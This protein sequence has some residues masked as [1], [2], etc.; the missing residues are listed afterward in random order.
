MCHSPGGENVTRRLLAALAAR[1]GLRR[2]GDPGLTGKCEDILS[3]RAFAE[4][5]ERCRE[6]TMTSL[7]R[8]YALYESTGY[9]IRAGIEGDLV[10]CGVWRGGSAMLMALTL[11]R[12]NTT[13]RALYLYDTFAG[14]TAPG[15]SDVD[16]RGDPAG[17]RWQSAQAADRNQW[18]YASQAEVEQNLCSTGYPA[19]RIR[20]VA[21]KVEETIP[22]VAPE[23]IALLRLDTD[24][25]ESTYHELRYLFPRLSRNGVLIVD[26]Y[27]HWRGCRR[28]VDQYCS[29]TG[30][31]L[32][33]HRIDYTGRI[34]I[35]P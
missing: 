19:E 22:R 27:G 17:P 29:E 15:V 30:T 20:L 34:A 18:C 2:A 33:L 6:Y 26:D 25:Y 14:M 23:R 35:R 16:H 8:M 5:Y 12:A 31:A 3:D 32:L 13:D 28:A 21:G 4:L 11:Q 24:W 9:I 10:E 7:E 1:F